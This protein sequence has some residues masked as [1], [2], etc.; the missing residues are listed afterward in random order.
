MADV[1][2]MYMAHAA[3]RR[4]F[5]LLPQLVRDVAPGDTRRAEVVGA[6]ADLMCLILHTHHEGEDLLLWPRLRERGGAE[7]EAIVPTMEAQHHAIEAA[8]AQVVALLPAFRA[9][10]RGGE[11]LAEALDALRAALIEHMDLE[12][13]EI[14]PL[15]EKHV[16]AAEWKGLGEHGM[17]HAPKKIL[18][19]VFGIAMYEGDPEVVKAVL[20]E[21]PG[22]ARLIMPI[23]APRLYASHARRVHGTATPPRG[24]A[25]TR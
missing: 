12:E 22:P 10:A 25:L 21:A 17:R 4:E 23:L 5:G 13:R 3:M 19:L 14:L 11:A 8:H 2:D 9:T 16:T 15:A 1:R 7:A 24:T 18:P 6:H 20:A